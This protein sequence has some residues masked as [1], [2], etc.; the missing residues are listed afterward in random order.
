VEKQEDD[1]RKKLLTQGRIEKW[2]LICVH[3]WLLLNFYVQILMTISQ[4]DLGSAASSSDH[5]PASPPVQEK[6]LG[7]SGT[8]FLQAGCPFRQK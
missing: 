8:K 4:C 2:S 3:S 7:I 6:N 1:P 5:P